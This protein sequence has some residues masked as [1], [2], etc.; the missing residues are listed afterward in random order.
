MQAIK[1]EAY[2]FRA[3]LMSWPFASIKN[4]TISGDKNVALPAWS[5]APTYGDILSILLASCL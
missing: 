2:S 4:V 3:L 5:N 1:G